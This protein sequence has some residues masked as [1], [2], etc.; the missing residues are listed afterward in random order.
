MIYAYWIVRRCGEV[1]LNVY[2]EKW[3]WLD[4]GKLMIGVFE[5]WVD[6]HVIYTLLMQENFRKYPYYVKKF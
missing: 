5:V 6:F 3:S 2:L 4:D 1:S